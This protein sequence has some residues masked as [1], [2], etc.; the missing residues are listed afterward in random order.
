MKRGTVAILIIL[1]IIIITLI[2]GSFL[3]TT[4]HNKES[5]SQTDAPQVNL[6]TEK[7]GLGSLCSS[8]AECRQFCQNNRGQC[9]AYCQGTKKTLCRTLFPPEENS[10]SAKKEEIC[11]SNSNPRFTS[12]FADIAKLTFISRYGNNGFN[13]PGSQT[14]SYVSVKEGESTPIYAPVNATITKIYFSDKNYTEFFKKEYIRPEYRIDIVV[15]CEVFIA[16]DHIVSLSDKL[17]TY[18]PQTPAPG[19]NDGVV[20]SIPVQAGEIIGY[21][22]GSFPGRAFDFL[23]LNR[24]REAQRLNSARWDT[25][26]SRYIGCPYDYFPENLKQQ[27]LSHIEEIKGI[28]DCGPTVKEIPNTAAGYWFQGNATESKGPR[29]GIAETKN[30]VSWILIK[31]NESPKEYRDNN[32][33]FPSLAAITEGKN[34]CYF[35]SNR[36]VYL[37]LK[38]L[39]NDKLAIV[40]GE[41]SCPASFPEE[42]AEVWER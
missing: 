14:R 6:V 9:E 35:D 12:P 29:F 32:G 2:I 15:S 17:K 8:E 13:N 20:V 28:R 30:F 10:V 1:T 36:K 34:A 7:Q 22:S 5:I 26:N 24:A 40:S 31:D 42:K 19:K 4:T 41:G 3:T 27:Y 25:D 37:Y 11:I 21:T 33:Q 38:M 39:P 23:V 16:F 18:A